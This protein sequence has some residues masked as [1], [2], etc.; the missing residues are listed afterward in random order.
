VK[1]AAAPSQVARERI[2]AGCRALGLRPGTGAVSQLAD[3][4][5]LLAK[6]NRVYNLT[7]VRSVP[8]MVVRH[9]L[10]SLAVVPYLKEG[11]L[12]DVGTGAGLPGLPLAIACPQLSVTLLDANA[13]KLRF[14]RQAVAELGLPNAVVVQARMQEYQPARAFDMVISRAVSSLEELYGLT[15]HLLAPGGRML[16]MKGA[17]PREEM[18]AFAPG[19]ET[20]HSVRL[21]VPGLEAERHLLWLDKQG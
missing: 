6:W 16:F 1:P 2:V 12:L 7:A 8:D 4:V 18:A 10:D 17:L 14:V 19:R 9:I 3:F 15:Q 13:K 21:Q 20:L 5:S 11:S